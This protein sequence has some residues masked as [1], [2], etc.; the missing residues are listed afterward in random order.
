M[1]ELCLHMPEEAVFQVGEG[2]LAELPASLR[3]FAKNARACALIS[4]QRVY[5]HFGSTLE[6]ALS[7][8]GVRQATFFINGKSALQKQVEKDSVCRFFDSLALTENDLCICLGGGAVCETGA[9]AAA[10]YK[11]GIP[12][13]CVPTG[14]LPMFDI[15]CRLSAGVPFHAP[16]LTLCDI[17]TLHSLTAV[18]RV[19]G[20][21]ELVRSA[22]LFGGDCLALLRETP[23]PIEKLVAADLF[24]KGRGIESGA[25]SGPLPGDVLARAAE[26]ADGYKLPRGFYIAAG[27]TAEIAAAQRRGLCSDELAPLAAELFAFF[28]V[29]SAPLPPEKE[30]CAAFAQTGEFFDLPL[31]KNVGD[32]ALYRCRRED[33]CRYY[34]T[35]EPVGLVAARQL[36]P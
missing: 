35:N 1:Q 34:F 22:L 20:F 31:L 12:C 2:L 7:S 13:V 11:G 23:T 27:L 19:S 32:M 30:L 25:L 29:G 3:R 21:A 18:Q 8:C 16:A 10:E 9:R 14:L 5:G 17:K 28:G 6:R 33:L 15:P 24:E 36:A 26:E 4:D